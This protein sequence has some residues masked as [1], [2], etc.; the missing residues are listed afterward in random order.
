MKSNIKKVLVV[1]LMFM[2]VFTMVACGNSD[3]DNGGSGDDEVYTLSATWCAGEATAIVQS[4]Y[5]A[6]EKIEKDS[7]GRIQV[8]TYHTGQISGSDRENAEK[9]STNVCQFT[10][11]PCATMAEFSGIEEYNISTIPYVCTTD[12]Q[13]DYLYDEGLYDEVNAAFTEQTG[14]VPNG[15]FSTGWIALGM[16]SGEVR[17]VADVKGKKVRSMTTE[18]QLSTLEAWGAAPT[19]MAIGELFT[20]LQQGTVDGALAAEQL[21]DSEGYGEILASVTNINPF[22]TYHIGIYNKEWYEALPDDLKVV[23]D[24]GMEYFYEVCRPAQLQATA[25]AYA[26]LE[27]AGCTFVELTDSELQAFAAAA[28][29]VTENM[30]ANLDATF[31][32]KAKDL[33]AAM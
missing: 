32:Q 18:G 25:D 2:L 17:S 5:K 9:V 3:S 20:A 8:K 7:N 26:N 6:A 21:F 16:K 12:A 23:F 27:A 31:V 29:S 24:E 15:S 10:T 11:I 1:A 19:P 33:L 22:S 28:T 13:L 14:L 30:F 4:W